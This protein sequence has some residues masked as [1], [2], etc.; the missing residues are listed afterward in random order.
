MLDNYATSMKRDLGCLVSSRTNTKIM[1]FVAI[2][3]P[4]RA[5]KI[6]YLTFIQMYVISDATSLKCS[7]SNNRSHPLSN[8]HDM[9]A[10]KTHFGGD[11]HLSIKH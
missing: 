2:D 11:Y 1:I 7:D 6:C 5:A 9:I 3:G 10:I 8:S 4:Q